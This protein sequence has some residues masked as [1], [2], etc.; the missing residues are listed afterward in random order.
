ME[1]NLQHD[2]SPQS[3]PG[4]SASSVLKMVQWGRTPTANAET[5]DRAPAQPEVCKNSN[6]NL[7]LKLKNKQNRQT[8]PLRAPRREFPS[9][10][11]DFNFNDFNTADHRGS[12]EQVSQRD[13]VQVLD[14]LLGRHRDYV[15]VLDSLLGRHRDYVQVLDSLRGRHRDYVQ[16]LDSLRGRHR[17]YVQV[18]D[19]LRGRHRDYVQVLDSLRGRH[20]DYVQVLDSLLGRHRDYVQVLDSLRGCHRDCVQVLDSLC[21]GHVTRGRHKQTRSS[22]YFLSVF[23]S[24]LHAAAV[25][26]FCDHICRFSSESE[27]M[28]SMKQLCGSLSVIRDAAGSRQACQSNAVTRELHLCARRQAGSSMQIKQTHPLPS[29]PAAPQGWVEI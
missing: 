26:G 8:R 2:S 25:V 15:Q 27:S 11:S 3:D 14:S 13:Y 19:S 6:T 10:F 18:L 12:N 24:L 29:L 4:S 1:E 9:N 20:R 7:K 17:D 23:E 28:L 22:T 5:W 16:V 21:P